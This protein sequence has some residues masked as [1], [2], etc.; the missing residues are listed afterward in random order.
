MIKFG[1]LKTKILQTLTEAYAM[2]KKDVIKDILKLMG[3]NKEFLNLYL[4]Y[5]EIENKNIEDKA[6]AEL[7]V[8][9]ITPLLQKFSIGLSKFCKELDKKIGGDKIVENEI[10]SNLDV[11]CESDSLK[12]IDQKIIAKKKLVEHLI[13]NKSIPDTTS[14]DIIENTFLLN[15][16]LSNNFNALYGNI[17]NEEE[18]KELIEIVSM[19]EKDLDMN[20]KSLQEEMSEKLNGMLVTESDDAKPKLTQALTETKSMKPTKFNYYKLQQLKKGL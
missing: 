3:G 12:N 11:L 13:L 14:T 4:F 15:T 19:T 20:F 2:G 1:T 8:E 18:K 6:H 17:L 9:E 5:E 16:V 7:F 10:Y